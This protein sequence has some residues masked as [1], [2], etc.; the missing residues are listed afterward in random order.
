MINTLHIENYKV[1]INAIIIFNDKINDKICSLLNSRAFYIKMVHDNMKDNER[2][3]N[4]NSRVHRLS[5]IVILISSGI[6]LVLF[7]Q[8]VKMYY[9]K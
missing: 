7:F 2:K 3:R 8:F 4:K 9:N 1:N 5:V 6:A